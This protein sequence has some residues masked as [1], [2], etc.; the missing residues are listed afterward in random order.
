M[1]AHLTWTVRMNILALFTQ[2]TCQLF[3]TIRST[4]I[5][6]TSFKCFRVNQACF[7]TW[8]PFSKPFRNER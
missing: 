8:R 3:F 6:A 2:T 7:C 1:T 5:L 4:V